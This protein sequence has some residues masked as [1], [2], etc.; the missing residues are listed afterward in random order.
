[1]KKSKKKKIYFDQILQSTIQTLTNLSFVIRNF[2]L[3]NKVAR[4]VQKVIKSNPIIE[5]ILDAM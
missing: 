3:I 1:M 2:Q 4:Q 5:M